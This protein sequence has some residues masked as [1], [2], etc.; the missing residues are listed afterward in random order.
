MLGKVRSTAIALLAA[1]ALVGCID[2]PVVPVDPQDFHPSLEINL[3][4]MTLQSGV[5]ILD[6]TVGGGPVATD[7]STIRVH[8][9]GWL[10]NGQLFGTSR[11]E[12]GEPLSFK[13]GEDVVIEGWELGIPGMKEGGVRKL[14][15]PPELAYGSQGNGPIHPNATLVFEVELVEVVGAAAPQ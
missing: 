8:Y 13:L 2:D 7:T 12:G 9:R 11:F 14:V 5:Y 6:T 15:V 3:D 10:K 1:V 4:E